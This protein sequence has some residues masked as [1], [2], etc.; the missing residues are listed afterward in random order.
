MPYI[1]KKSRPEYDKHIQNIVEAWRAKNFPV[2]DVNYVI[3]RM[4]LEWFFMRKR[5]A[6]LNAIRGVLGCVW[7]EL[8]RRHG[9]PYEDTAIKKNGDIQPYDVELRESLDRPIKKGK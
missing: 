5:Y 1:V 6:T 9:A 3:T 7:D 8:W 4:M 2:G